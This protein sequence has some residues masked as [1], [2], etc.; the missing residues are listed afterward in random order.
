M[1]ALDFLTLE[2]LTW[3]FLH[4]E[5]S[6]SH[7]SNLFTVLSV[8]LGRLVWGGTCAQSTITLY[9]GGNMGD[10]ELVGINSQ[11]Q[12][13][14]LVFAVRG[15]SPGS[16]AAFLTK[17]PLPRVRYEC[18]VRKRGYEKWSCQEDTNLF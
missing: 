7:G 5:D 17:L 1:F 16:V 18:Q 14:S 6:S 2:E 3:D 9:S 13:T 11:P 10:M 8:S 12:K 15:P 4:V